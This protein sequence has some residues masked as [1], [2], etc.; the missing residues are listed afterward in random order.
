[1]SAG[2]RWNLADELTKVGAELQQQAT[3]RS[4]RNLT[5][6]VMAEALELVAAAQVT[7]GRAVSLLVTADHHE[8][9]DGGT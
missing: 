2:K 9:D 4:G 5:D 8:E 1:V 6:P 3:S 7:L